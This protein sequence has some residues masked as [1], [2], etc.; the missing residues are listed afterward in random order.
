MDNGEER[1]PVDETLVEF[2]SP[3]AFARQRY[4]VSQWTLAPCYFT[5]PLWWR[6]TLA[7]RDTPN[8]GIRPLAE[9]MQQVSAQRGAGT[10]SHLAADFDGAP[11]DFDK[12]IT[13]ARSLGKV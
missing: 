1:I 10:K 9:W 6:G 11:T 2:R 12:A 13:P 8:G 5:A 7:P 3:A 4:C